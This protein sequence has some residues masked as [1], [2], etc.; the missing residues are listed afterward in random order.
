MMPLDRC[1]KPQKQT[2]FM[3][4]NR[5]SLSIKISVPLDDNHLFYRPDDHRAP[6]YHDDAHR[7]VKLTFR[8]HIFY[9]DVKFDE[10]QRIHSGSLLCPLLHQLGFVH[11]RGRQGIG[12]SPSSIHN[13]PPPLSERST[14]SEI[15]ETGIK[16][17]DV[18]VPLERGGKAGLF[19]DGRGG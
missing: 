17:I 12:T 15:F 9:R 11:E 3:G 18:L 10:M 4:C 13:Q 19:G 16:A 1:R 2:R 7:E 8:D 5:F 14:S 6:S